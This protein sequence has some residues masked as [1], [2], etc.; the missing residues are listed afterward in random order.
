M[1]LAPLPPPWKKGET[2]TP[3]QVAR[4][5]AYLVGNLRRTRLGRRALRKRP[6]LAGE[7]A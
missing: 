4:Y 7:D 6:W 2:P 1:G 3:E 5:R